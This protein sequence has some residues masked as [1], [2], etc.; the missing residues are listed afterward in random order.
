V[1][2]VYPADQSRP[3]AAL[4]QNE[5]SPEG[6]P[7][8][9]NGQL[10]STLCV[11]VCGERERERERERESPV[12]CTKRTCTLSLQSSELCRIWSPTRQCLPQ[13]H[14]APHAEHHSPESLVFPLTVQS[15]HSP[16]A[17][18]CARIQEH[19]HPHF[20][21]LLSDTYFRQPNSTTRE[22]EHG[23]HSLT[24]TQE[25]VCEKVC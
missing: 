6:A 1:V 16:G 14:T 8:V 2:R 25:R 5:P 10:K 20:F 3:A 11:G 23:A 22:H 15:L 7:C 18:V 24:H 19:T 17:V 21:L 9:N 13:Y 4:E 12:N